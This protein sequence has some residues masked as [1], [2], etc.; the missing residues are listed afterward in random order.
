[1]RPAASLPDPRRMYY[2]P[3]HREALV[4]PGELGD[5]V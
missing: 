1:M 2:F 5:Y 3:R 4:L